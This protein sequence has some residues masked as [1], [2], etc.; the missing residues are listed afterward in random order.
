MHGVNAIH[1]SSTGAHACI[2]P[3]TSTTIGMNLM[4]K[5]LDSENHPSGGSCKASAC[6]CGQEQL[7]PGPDAPVL[8]PALRIERCLSGSA[9]PTHLQIPQAELDPIL[10][11]PC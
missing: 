6:R 7:V 3:H 9:T 2:G 4:C 1:A 11:A 8:G 10:R 5:Q